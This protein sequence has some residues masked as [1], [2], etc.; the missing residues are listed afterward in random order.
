MKDGDSVTEHLNA[1]NTVVSQLL[2]VDIKISDEDKCISLLCSL[3]DSWNSLVIAIGSNATALQ[4]DEI[5]SALLTE[6]MRRKNM[7]N[8]NGD[9]LSVRGRSQNRNKNK[10]SSG[11]SKS[12]G[13]SKSP[14]KP[15][16]VVCWKCGKEGHFKGSVNLKLLIKEKDLTMLLL[17]RQKPPQMK[18]GMCVKTVFEKDTCKMVRGALVLMRGVRIGTLYKLQGSTVV[19]GCNSSMVPENG[20]ENLVV[21]GEKTMLWHQ[22]LGHIGEKGL[23]ILHGKGMVEGMSNSSLD[24]DFCENCVYGK[25][26]RVS[27]PSGGKRTK[28]ILELVHSDVFGP[29]KVPSLGNSVKTTP[30]YTSKNWGARKIRTRHLMEMERARSMLSGVGLGQE[31]WAEAVDTACYLVN[32]S[33]SSAL[34]DKT[35]KKYGLG[36]KLWTPVTRKVVYSR[37]VVFRE[38]KD[39]IKHEV[40]PKEPVK[41]E[42]ELKEEKSD[43]TV[44]EAVDS[45]DG[46]LWKEAMVD[47]MASLHKNEAWDLVKLPAGRKPI[48]SKWV[49]KKKTNAE[50]KVEKYKARLVAKEQMDVKTAFLH[51]DLEEEIYM[52]QPEGF[53]V[54]GKKELV[55]KLKKSL[56]GLKQSPRMWYQKFDTFIRGLGFTRSKAD[57]CVYFKLIGDRVIY[58]VLYVDDMLLFGNDKEIIQDLKTQLSSKFDMK[59]L[60]AANYI[61]GMELKEIGQRGSFG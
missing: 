3:P 55:C 51:G 13:R 56:Y 46:K 36:Y 34:E 57:H 47:E 24:F 7:D 33:P 35:H 49:F 19:D 42:F 32:R 14:G 4:F 59:D 22:R 44:K 5:V 30:Y 27:F 9:A 12:R 25:Q 21:S 54:K 20:A 2:F 37:D 40:Q 18:V 11:R 38:V 17:Q 45:E 15:T 39:V 50:G 16:K 43:L 48:G 10:S 41:I 28:Q 52:K 53:A 31:F 58:L 61:L 60:G 23:R 8:Q 29:V 6:E 26:S 1:F